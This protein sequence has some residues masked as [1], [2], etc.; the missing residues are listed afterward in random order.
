M[1]LLWFTGCHGSLSHWGCEA[2]LLAG[3]LDNCQK[4]DENIAMLE[5]DR[6][7]C[8]HKVDIPVILINSDQHI[9]PIYLFPQWGGEAGTCLCTRLTLQEWCLLPGKCFCLNVPHL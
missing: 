6:S 5:S 7:N 1:C 3:G 2:P 9:L 8:G 4:T